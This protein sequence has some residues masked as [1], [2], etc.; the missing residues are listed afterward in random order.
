MP[1][2]MGAARPTMEIDTTQRLHAGAQFVPIGVT[3]DAAHNEGYMTSVTC[4]PTLG[5]WVGLG[6]LTHGPERIGER[7]RACDPLRNREVIVEVCS[8][9]FVDP[10]GGRLRG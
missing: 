8:P 2:G 4:S 10:E 9:H 6:L 5:C 3:A 7:I 1:T